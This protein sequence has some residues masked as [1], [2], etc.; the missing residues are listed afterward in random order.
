MGSDLVARKMVLQFAVRVIGQLTDFA[1]MPGLG[2]NRRRQAGD[3]GAAGPSSGGAPSG[4]T[5]RPALA[6]GTAGSK[7][8]PLWSKRAVVHLT[9]NFQVSGS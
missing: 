9:G 6:A 3:A 7:V 2:R 1:Y 5:G 4:V 8:A